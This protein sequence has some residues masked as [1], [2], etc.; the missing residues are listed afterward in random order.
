[1]KTKVILFGALAAAMSLPLSAYAADDGFYLGFDVGQAHY[2]GVTGS[3]APFGGISHVSDSDTGY[4]FTGG[5]QFNR[6]WGAEASYVDFG[7]AE[8]N[9]DVTTPSAGSFA[10]KRQA[11]GF[12]F[13]GTGTYPFND[14]WSIFGRL[15]GVMG[16]VKVD[17]TGTGSLATAT[18]TQT[19]SDWKVTYGAGVNWKLAE[20]WIVRA[21]WDQ[22]SSLGNQN[23]TGESDVNLA[24]IGVVYRF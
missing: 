20:N 19:S 18:A 7:Q 5:Y 16:H 4:R 21:G 9:V 12:V 24:S 23:K 3:L 22:Y 13:A 11:H 2:S 17:A 1:M 10:A 14:T 15:G 6:Y 8:A